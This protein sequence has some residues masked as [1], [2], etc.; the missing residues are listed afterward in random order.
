MNGV[1]V[2]TALSTPL[3]PHLSALC[4]PA[5]SGTRRGIQKYNGPDAIR[6]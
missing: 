1:L 2:R 4:A 5:G 6:A 3:Y